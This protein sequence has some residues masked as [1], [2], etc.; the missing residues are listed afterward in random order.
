L[1]RRAQRRKNSCCE[2]GHLEYQ[3]APLSEIRT[4]NAGRGGEFTV[5]LMGAAAS[6]RDP[7][8][9][10][11]KKN[12]F[13]IFDGSCWFKIG[14]ISV[15]TMFFLWELRLP[16]FSRDSYKYI[17]SYFWSGTLVLIMQFFCDWNN[18]SKAKSKT[19]FSFL[20]I[21]WLD[22]WTL[23]QMRINPIKFCENSFSVCPCVC[24]AFFCL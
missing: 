15:K 10:V 22:S 24:D 14:Y 2:K 1:L 3:P 20:Q 23:K 4:H 17:Q 11:Q 12:C 13:W 5:I 19:F 18:F 6:K 8:G 9:P 7:P 21:C 16:T